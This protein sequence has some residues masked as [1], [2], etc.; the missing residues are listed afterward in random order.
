MSVGGVGGVSDYPLAVGHGMS[1]V[2]LA[3]DV[4]GWSRRQHCECLHLM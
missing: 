3:F 1:E 2:V 4:S